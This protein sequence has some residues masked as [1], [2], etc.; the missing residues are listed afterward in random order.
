MEKIVL[1]QRRIKFLLYVLNKYNRKIDDINLLIYK[2]SKV[3]LSNYNKEILN[4]FL[5]NKNLSKLDEISSIIE[6][7]PKNVSLKEFRFGY[8]VKINNCYNILIDV[9][10][11]CGIENLSSLLNLQNLKI[12]DKELLLF[13]DNTFSITENSIFNETKT[14][15]N[16]NKLTVY[17]N[18][19]K[20]NVL[21]YDLVNVSKLD[22]VLFVKQLKKNLSF[23]E[24]VYGCRIYLKCNKNVV[25]I[26]NGYFN[27]DP[28][29]V[30]RKSSIF[31]KKENALK[32]EL[33]SL[34][35]SLMFKN[36]YLK[37]L[38]L[39]DFL[40]YDE[41]T[42][43]E[44]IKNDYF[45]ILNYKNKS[46][47][48][49]VKDFLNKTC[50]EQVK[51]ITLFIMFEEDSEIQNMAYLLYDM[52]T[53]ESYLL[54][55]SLDGHYIFNSLHWSLQKSFKVINKKMND[56]LKKISNFNFENISYEK[57]IYMMKVNT[58]TKQ[59]AMDKLKEISNKSNENCS[60][61][62]QYLDNLLKIPF[63]VFQKEEILSYIDKFKGEF[64]Y[65]LKNLSLLKIDS[66]VNNICLNILK[67]K[68]LYYDEMVFVIR[69]LVNYNKLLNGNIF[70]N[71]EFIVKILNNYVK[72][73]NIIIEQ[74]IIDINTDLLIKYK[75]KGTKKHYIKI[76]TKF[77]QDKSIDF[78]IRKKH[79]GTISNTLNYTSIKKQND[80]CGNIISKL[81]KNLFNY[82]NN[83]SKYLQQSSQTLDNAIYGQQEAKNEIKRIIS[84]WINGDMTG[85]CLGFEG[86]PGTGKT[87][88]AKQGISECLKDNNSS[89]PFSFIALGGSS[90]GSTLEG[91]N[92]TY[93]GSTHGKIVDILIESKCM[94]PII[95]IDELDK[96]SNT[97]NGKELIG[98]LT[99]L[100]DSSQNEHFNDKYF[101]GIDFDLSKVLF[102]FSYN[103]YS[104]LDKILADRIHRIKFNYMSTNDKVII[105]N[106]YLIP[107][108]LKEVGLINIINFD[109]DIIK[110]I[111]YNYTME[112]GV[113]KLKERIFE[114][115][116]QINLN[117]L[118]DNNY[119]NKLEEKNLLKNDKIM[120]NREMVDEIFEKKIKLL[121]KTIDVKSK[122]GLVNGL[123]ATS[124]GTGGITMIE[125][126]KTFHETKLSLV[127]TGQQ[128]SVMKESI[129]CAKTIAWNILP[130]EF[131]NKIN[132]VLKKNSFG[133]HIHCPEAS[134]PKDGPSAGTAITIAILSLLSN[135]NVRNNVALTGEIDL[136]GNVLAVG[137]IDLK[138]EGG[139]NAGVDTILLPKENQQDFNILVKTKPELKDSL[140]IIFV[141][142]VWEVIPHIFVENNFDFVNYTNQ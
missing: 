65:N 21:N 20:N 40:I 84:Q 120:L 10:K 76:L 114:I 82:N 35:I 103:D 38:T 79:F 132:T 36:I 105:M 54:K 129:I 67:K 111:I 74:F 7:I 62:T 97:E 58:G 101:A 92:Y 83:V 24:N 86:P 48:T 131:Q 39:R 18:N 13:L 42:L 139:K 33:K 3:I 102:I 45:L 11:E 124:A 100:T 122:I 73:K 37:Q 17:K 112:G 106:N 6:N 87:T 118:S 123:Y 72:N 88:I 31:I 113:R 119:L 93:L 85:Y 109:V 57:K 1:A 95:Y 23:I 115:I 90:N 126:L 116:R 137:G 26:I 75:E 15:T 68:N 51:F 121:Q 56:E 140:N 107:K 44:Q 49:L 2:I 61:A 59:K 12:E 52:I 133:I 125:A 9:S 91:H 110:Y 16:T 77:F 55:P 135:I 8:L 47:S 136:N 78:N 34:N 130:K 142:N 89:R 128:G 4:Q 19:E 96:I 63:G 99:H 127:I 27:N 14:K 29:N 41:T 108:L 22:K 64:F 117:L 94:N 138:I 53:N 98:I 50:Y 134:T 25:L 81:N 80:K 43:A 71:K 70:E 5:Y 28:I 141:S 46:L 30:F 69:K 60:K 66:E 104:K 32:E